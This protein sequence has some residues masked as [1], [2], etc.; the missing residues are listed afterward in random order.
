MRHLDP[1]FPAEASGLGRILFQLGRALC[2]WIPGYHLV[3]DIYGKSSFKLR[4]IRADPTFFRIASRIISDRKS[5]LYYDRMFTLYQALQ[6]VS[7]S[8]SRDERAFAVEVGAYRGGST[9]LIAEVAAELLGA[10]RVTCHC[11]DTFEG[12]SYEDLPAGRE[13]V[14]TAVKFSRTSYE[15]VCSYLSDLPFVR[16]T[17]GRIQEVAREFTNERVHL[18]HLDVDIYEPTLFSL[19]FFWE[20]MARGGIIVV[21][22]YGFSTCPGVELAVT[23]FVAGRSSH[24]GLQLMTGQYVLAKT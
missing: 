21:D 17:R 14:H 11:I 15:E 19:E 20:R 1:E 9:R 10:D 12:H 5:R 6:S 18:L 22:D 2:S 4:D 16:V 3:P 13:G 24:V 23:E 8:L 7:R